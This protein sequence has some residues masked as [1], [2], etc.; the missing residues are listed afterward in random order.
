M[1]CYTA[2]MGERGFSTA[3]LSAVALY[4][5]LAAPGARAQEGEAAPPAEGMLVAFACGTMDRQAAIDVEALDDTPAQMTLRKVI[6]DELARHGFRVA[7]DARQRLTFEG[8]ISRE[9]TE[10]GRHTVGELQSNNDI[11]EFRLNMWSSRGD[12]VLGGVQDFIPANDPNQYRLTIFV[13]DRSNGK[14]LWQGEARHTVA[15]H[16]APGTARRLVPM[17]LDDLGKTVNATPFTLP[18]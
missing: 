4:L 14:C 17:L 15:D 9:F 1:R 8:G 7:G 6:A 11:T 12:S 3:W 13:H 16:D 2:R 18:E 10:Q 5:A